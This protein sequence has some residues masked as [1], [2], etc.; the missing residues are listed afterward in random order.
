MTEGGIKTSLRPKKGLYN[1]GVKKKTVPFEEQVAIQSLLRPALTPVGANID[2]RR[3]KDTLDDIS[4][5]LTGSSLESQA[6]ELAL[7]DC[8]ST[9]PS[10]RARR[11]RFAVESLRLEILRHLLGRPSLRA[12]SVMVYQSDLLADF[13]GLLSLEGINKASKST[14]DR[15]SRLFSEDQLRQLHQTIVEVCG[16]SELVDLVGL[17]EAVCMETCLVDSTCLEADIHYP[18]DWVLLRDVSQTLLKAMKLIRREGVRCRMPMEPEGFAQEM[19]QLCI[20]MTHARRQPD[21]KRNRKKILRQMKKLLRTIGEHARRHEAKLRTHRSMTPWSH[22]QMEQICERIHEM[23]G[24]LDTVIK[25]AHERIIGGRK[26]SNEDKLLSVY[27][28]D[29]H[30]LVRGKAGKEVEFGNTL[31]LNEN[32]QGM[33]LDYRLYREQAPAEHKQV[34]ESLERVKNY[35]VDDFIAEVCSD[36]GASAKSL[37]K[38]LESQGIYDATCPKSVRALRERMQE[39]PFRCLQKR[40]GSTEGRIGIVKNKFMGGR[41]L[42]KSFERRAQAVGW[43]VLAHN[44]WFIAKACAQEREEKSAAKAA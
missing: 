3:F 39:E 12:F 4:N 21:A 2:Y 30:V 44:L 6:M 23:L 42:A 27:N 24:K 15:R 1:F 32:A 10:A 16:N 36:R 31:F 34:K 18:V 33:V 19:N 14:L 41:I 40:R 9:D 37:S 7:E 43:A 11:A 35:H 28:D 13:C 5:A 25:Q 26:V 38:Q 22:R 29:V 8:T 20:K 17:S